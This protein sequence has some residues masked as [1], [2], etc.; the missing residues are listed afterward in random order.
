MSKIGKHNAIRD[1][2]DAAAKAASMP[3]PV[4]I[5]T[6]AAIKFTA[7]A[8]IRT[9]EGQFNDDGTINP[10]TE[11]SPSGIANGAIHGTGA[12]VAQLITELEMYNPDSKIDEI[13]KGTIFI[14][15]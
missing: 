5:I 8:I 7:D 11:D 13:Y 14:K 4:N 12:T 3:F 1:Q 15:D 9:P 2:S 10:K 6:I